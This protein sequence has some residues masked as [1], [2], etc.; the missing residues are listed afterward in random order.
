M[1][2]RIFRVSLAILVFSFGVGHSLF[3]DDEK[4]ASNS[5]DSAKISES[6]E[7]SYM[8][9]RE[10]LLDG[11]LE[12]A[13]P[14]FEAALKKDPQSA[15]LNEEMAELYL[16][17]GNLER[18]EV[19]C[20]KA[21]K[22]EPKNPQYRTT[23][24]GI[25]ASQKRFAEAKEQYSK[26]L[27]VDPNNQKIPL[28]LGI[29]E[30]EDGQ[31]EEG[32]KILTKAIETN[33]DNYMAYFYRAKVYLEMEDVQ[34]AKADL[35]KALTIRPAFVEAGT[36][37]GMLHERLGDV[38]AAIAAYSRIQG[39]GAFKKRLGQ[40][41]L[42]K[43]EFE[44]ALTEFKEYEEVESDDYTV[45]VKI[46]L[47]YFELKKYDDAIAKFKVILKEQP[48]AGNVRFYLG[49]VYEEMKQTD[50]A[51]TEF[52]QVASDSTFFKESMLHV[53]LLY[54]DGERL[55]EGAE[56]S[57]KLLAS[58]S[59]VPEFYDMYASFFEAKKD[60]KHAV[61]VLED[62]LKH[63]PKDE[64]LLYFEGALNDKLG[65]K[66]HSIAT[67]KKILELNA[68]NAH[69]LN[70]LGYTY[71][72]MGQNLDEAQS[73]IE[74]ALTLR[75]QDGYIEDSLGWVYFKRGKVDDAIAQL[76]KAADLEKEEP[77]I[78]EHLGDVYLSK[79]DY[80][81]AVEMY[82]KAED[83]SNRKKD[84]D[85][86]KKMENKIASVSKEQRNPTTEEKASQ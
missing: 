45:K 42:S 62:G 23:L 77:I 30:A 57:K 46:G 10:K 49:V 86:V 25:Y 39:S 8:K 56:F 43:N 72:D 2:Y 74:K 14:F 69:A 19:L 51:I 84:S 71:A 21:V 50:K 6:D 26:I 16:R 66:T 4:L 37:L 1:G 12:G 73:M 36:A 5:G 44:K 52:K 83:L 79:K 67:M 31:L 17:L 15:S 9:G 58:H 20:Q 24:G 35:D 34:K 29:L 64:K 80:S 59:D 48:D 41:Y 76:N 78:F 60:Y 33:S 28:L 7:L 54:K 55:K 82:K 61:S 18:A 27:E 13:V 22:N 63:F 75:P 68:N 47:I 70:F 65:D 81:K 32:A 11:D 85:T 38:D 40:L 53:G 3:A